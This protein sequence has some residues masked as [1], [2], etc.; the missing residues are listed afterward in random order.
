[1]L[2]YLVLVLILVFNSL[3]QEDL[4]EKQQQGKLFAQVELSSNL[5]EDG[6]TQTNHNFALASDVGY[7]MEQFRAGV[8]GS[9]V[10]FPNETTHLTLQP[11]FTIIA[12]FNPTSRIMVE[13]EQR[14]YYGQSHRITGKTLVAFEFDR[15]RF[16]HETINNWWGLDIYKSRYGFSY[17][18]DWR[19][20]LYSYFILGY[21]LVGEANTPNFFD[22]A[23]SLHWK[24]GPIDY[25]GELIALSYVVPYISNGQSFTYRLGASAQF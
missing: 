3:A 5:L 25:F 23:A 17:R 14:L 18:A 15:Y 20:A 19:N 4:S 7:L 2:H 12:H 16:K 9:N 22:V 11:Y 13:Y 10:S 8:R 1:M 6:Y 24:D 21:N